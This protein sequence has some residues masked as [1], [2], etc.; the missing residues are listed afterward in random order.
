[1]RYPGGKGKVYQHVINVLPPHTTYIETHLGGGA[2]L[3]RKKP[4]ALTIGVDRDPAVIAYWRNLFPTLGSYFEADAAEFLTSQHFRGSELVY[5]DPPYLPETRRKSRVYRYDYSEADHIR[6][7]EVVRKLR[8]R[9]VIS[10]YPSRLY[11]EHLRGWSSISFDAKTHSG[12]RKERLWFN[13]VQPQWLHDVRYLGRDFRE[14]QTIKRRLE[15]LKVHI[16]ALSSQEQGA[17]FDWLESFCKVS[18]QRT[19]D[20]L[21]PGLVCEPYQLSLLTA[22]ESE[23]DSGQ[24]N[25]LNVR[26][27]PQRAES[28]DKPNV[29]RE[30]VVNG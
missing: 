25:S 13:F 19:G 22:L 21:I 17:L 15:R 11:D 6:L 7:L 14:R 2:V 27:A 8:S 4:A 18:D 29:Y 10:G 5:C 12:I 3:L 26:K 16:A 24:G 9:I 23:I 1:M 30:V 20:T 28:I